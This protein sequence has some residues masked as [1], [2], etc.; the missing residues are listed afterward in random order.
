LKD[1]V[2]GRF[3]TA[4]IEQAF[5]VQ[6]WPTGERRFGWGFIKLEPLF[7]ESETRYLMLDSDIV[8]LG[9]VIDALETF[10]TDFVVQEETQPAQ[11]VPNLYFDPAK[12]RSAF[13]AS[14]QAPAFTFNSGQY[15][16]RS[17]LIRR[18]DFANLV[19]WSE[20]RRVRYTDMF[21]PGDQGV[22]NYV[23][24]Q[25]VAE[26]SITVARTPF[27]KWG[28]EEMAEFDLSQLNDTSP[29]PFVIHWAGLKKLRLRHMLRADILRH[30]ER[31][32]YARIP[33]GSARHWLRLTSDEVERW[34]KRAMRV[35]TGV[36][37][38]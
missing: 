37:W 26:G 6:L 15:V 28:R 23:V 30:F 27:M 11:D 17:G 21:N 36:R 8:F 16:A 25:R 20:P 31:A 7:D 35:A 32:Y 1:A 22:L 4:E 10:D 24:L 2:N 3:D 12:I 14:M 13:N 18:E 34:S 29:Y 19:V 33:N 38:S 5:D 9:P